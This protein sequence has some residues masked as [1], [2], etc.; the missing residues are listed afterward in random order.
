MALPFF[1]GAEPC[2]RGHPSPFLDTK[3]SHD[4]GDPHDFSATYNKWRMGFGVPQQIREP[5]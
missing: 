2:A 3:G 4:C 1:F 5:T